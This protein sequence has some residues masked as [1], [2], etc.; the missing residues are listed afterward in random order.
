MSDDTSAQE[1]TEQPTPK[2]L[3]KAREQGQVPRSRELNT[4]TVTVVGALGFLLFGG[5]MHARLA[6]LVTE[7]LVPAGAA[8]LEDGELFEILARGVTESLLL[9]A[10][11]FAVLIVAAIA[12]PASLGGV[13][14]SAE[15][16]MPKL[17]RL[18]P[19]KGLGRIFSAQGAMELVKTLLKF[20]VLTSAAAALLW[21]L[22]DDL[23][24]LGRGDA[25]AGISGAGDMVGRAFLILACCLVLIA[26][27]DVPFQLWSHVKRLRMTRQEIKEE[28]K[29]SEG[30]PEMRA[31]VRRMQQE[32]SR[33]RMM[34]DV[35]LADVVITNPTHYAVALRYTDRPDRAPRV[36]AKGRGHVAARI[37]ELADQ[38]GV[39][40]CS[41][42]PL[43]RAIY[44][45][46]DVGGDI[47]TALYLAVAR[48]L[49]WV[50]QLKTARST[51][52]A[53]PDFPQDLPVPDELAAGAAVRSSAGASRAA[54]ARS[55]A[56]ESRAA[57][58]AAATASPREPETRA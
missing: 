48:V 27:I 25:L 20:T 36:V 17:S 39:P 3:Q 13:T 40:V 35:P 41:A 53:A 9:L 16:A 12:G 56:A 19:L 8:S 24:A 42:P 37:R 11:L 18:S 45:H 32:V 49:V 58:D 55:S 15:G 33:R 10:P 54:D 44:F 7:G 38:H 57:A 28:L 6:A 31:R 30:N 51:G 34:A 2:R 21:W 23:L 14:F 46:T 1:R 4:M 50:M 47:P 22:T 43:A 5:W 52:A 26:A 29:E